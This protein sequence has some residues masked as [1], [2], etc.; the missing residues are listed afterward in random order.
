[1]QIGSCP[2]GCQGRR[3]GVWWGYVEMGSCLKVLGGAGTHPVGT[4]WGQSAVSSH[5]CSHRA[6]IVERHPD[7]LL[8][9]S[10]GLSGTGLLPPACLHPGQNV[11]GILNVGGKDLT[12]LEPS[13]PPPW[14]SR[15]SSL[16]IKQPGKPASTPV[17]P[18]HLYCTINSFY[19]QTRLG[20]VLQIYPQSTSDTK[21]SNSAG[22]IKRGTPERTGPGR[23]EHQR[24]RGAS[25][26]M[27]GTLPASLA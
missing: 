26:S 14:S 7:L 5:G 9:G 17:F 12:D 10:G 24:R 11:E 16:V 1:M 8:Q 15:Q 21:I 3:V 19:K 23:G 13:P 6:G 27:Q 22:A 25:L 2:E 4:V 20:S 18:K